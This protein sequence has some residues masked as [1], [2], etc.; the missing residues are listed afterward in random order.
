MKAQTNFNSKRIAIFR[1]Y[2]WVLIFMANSSPL[3]YGQATDYFEI[4]G[5]VTNAASGKPIPEVH[6]SVE[7]TNVSGLANNNGV[8][9]L[10][11]PTEFKNTEVRF[12][13][14]NYEPKSVPISFFAN[15][16]T[17][18]SLVP[19]TLKA[20][21]QDKVEVYRAADPRNVEEKDL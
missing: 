8:F 18:I 3:L 19:T 13:K 6:L 14:I 21:E 17:A 9:T 1:R 12:F 5:Q 16:F 11:I 10:K 2:F 20:E 4:K 15:D 7:N